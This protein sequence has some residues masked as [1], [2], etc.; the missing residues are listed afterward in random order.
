[1]MFWR[2]KPRPRVCFEYDED[3]KAILVT[4]GWPD[5]S[6]AAMAAML[7]LINCG[8]LAAVAASSVMAFGHKHGRSAE[9]AEVAEAAA[10]KKKSGPL[11]C[12]LAVF[13]NPNG[14][15]DG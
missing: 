5:G 11:V 8:E 3:K 15:G 9:A 14:G 10:P 6:A 2:K 4:A 12:P 1:M 13:G 7:G